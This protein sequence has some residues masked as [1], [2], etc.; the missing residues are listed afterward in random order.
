MNRKLKRQTENIHSV[1]MESVTCSTVG[2]I[3][4]YSKQI[5]MRDCLELQRGQNFYIKIQGKE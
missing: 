2:I 4:E 3:G 5:E 1:W